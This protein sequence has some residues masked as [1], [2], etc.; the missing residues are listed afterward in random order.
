MAT[1]TIA[2]EAGPELSGSVEAW[3]LAIYS[4]LTPPQQQTVLARVG[5]IDREAVREGTPDDAT[6]S[7]PLADK[8]RKG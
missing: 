8:R 7:S 4:I 5:K 2:R 3:V 6:F 1:I